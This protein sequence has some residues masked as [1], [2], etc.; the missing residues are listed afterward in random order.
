MV[1]LAGLVER[2]PADD[3]DDSRHRRY[4]GWHAQRLSAPI[5]QAIGRGRE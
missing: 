1:T 4:P 3:R 2:L 5:P